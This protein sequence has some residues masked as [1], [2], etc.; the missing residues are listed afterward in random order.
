MQ[1]DEIKKRQDAI[2]KPRDRALARGKSNQEYHY[3]G[4]AYT[5]S[6]IGEAIAKEMIELEKAGNETLEHQ[7]E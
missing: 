3:L 7:S 6:R 4:S 1:A 5:Y 2:L